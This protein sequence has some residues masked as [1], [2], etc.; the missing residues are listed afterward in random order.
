MANQNSD[1]DH[2]IAKT[3][4]MKAVIEQAKKF[5]ML[6]APLLIQGETGTGKDF[7]AKACHQFSFRREQ[8]FIA[9]NCAGLPAEEAES[10]M[11]GRRSNGQESMGF[12]EYAHGG[13]V[14]LDSV[15]ELSLEMQAKLLRFLNDGSFRRVGEDNEIHVDVRVICTSQKALST[16]V[17]EGKVR[18]DLYHRLNVLTLNL[19]RLCERQGDLPALATQFIQQI[20]QQ[21]GIDVPQYDEDFIQALRAYHWPGNLREL[22]NALYRACSLAVNNQL[23][24]ADLNLPEDIPAEW[25]V[26]SSSMHGTLE[27]LVNRFEASLLRKFYAEYPSTRKLAQRLGISHTAVANKLRI[28]GISK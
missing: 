5:A 14:L 20:S 24:V 19:P 21:L 15:A 26:E 17:A 10:E 2:I 8:R 28:Y 4:K 23:A 6:N 25:S 13:T 11:F 7:F 18:E 22:Y 3:A 9:V 1:F 16:L 27:E 12:F